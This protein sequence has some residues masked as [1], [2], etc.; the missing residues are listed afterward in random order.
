[1][2]SVDFC[3]LPVTLYIATGPKQKDVNA[4]TTPFVSVRWVLT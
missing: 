3:M 1:M 4:L 2:I